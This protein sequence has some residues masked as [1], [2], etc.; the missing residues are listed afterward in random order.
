MLSL[1]I[2]LKPH[3]IVRIWLESTLVI[4]FTTKKNLRYLWSSI[5]NNFDCSFVA[6]VQWS[7]DFHNGTHLTEHN[8][9]NEQMHFQH[10]VNW[11]YSPYLSICFAVLIGFSAKHCMCIQHVYL[12]IKHWVHWNQL[13]VTVGKRKNE[14]DRESNNVTG[15]IFLFNASHRF[16]ITHFTILCVSECVCYWLR[17]IYIW[18]CT[19]L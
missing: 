18:L 5:S 6:K 16:S 17:I 8:V 14:K 19:A 3:A 9:L 12:S 10:K 4:E 15:A 1:K 7:R 2:Q 11:Q 13:I